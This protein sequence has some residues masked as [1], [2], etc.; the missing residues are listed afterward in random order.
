[1]FV[2]IAT[3]FSL[4]S[5]IAEA[6]RGWG[7][8]TGCT[9]Y[10][11]LDDYFWSCAEPH[12][13]RCK[14]KACDSFLCPKMPS[15]RGYMYRPLFLIEVTTRWGKSMFADAYPRI[16]AKH[17][18]WAKRWYK[19]RS[20]LPTNNFADSGGSDGGESKSFFW[21]ARTLAVP[22]ATEAFA[23]PALPPMPGVAASV[24]SL[25]Y[26]ISEFV[27]DQWQHGVGGIEAD[28]KW[29]LVYPL[30]EMRGCYRPGNV[31]T[32]WPLPG[33]DEKKRDKNKQGITYIFA[34]WRKKKTSCFP[35][36]GGTTWK[37]MLIEATYVSTK[38]VCKLL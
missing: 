6:G 24:P 38:G 25:Y 28:D 33:P 18:N 21:H 2:L 26:G 27:V 36:F 14:W 5:L 10:E 35:P 4:I 3:I 22:F 8:V 11:E 37:D 1:M 31:A 13:G 17:F 7:A 15:K 30:T 12:F 19:S 20:P 9:F 32:D 23:Y 29:Q 34:I 16:L